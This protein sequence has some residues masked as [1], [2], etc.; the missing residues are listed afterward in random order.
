M[1][2]RNAE[3]PQELFYWTDSEFNIWKG[4]VHEHEGEVMAGSFHSEEPHST[5]FK[6]VL[7]NSK[8]TKV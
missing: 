3:V 6:N 5:L 1:V 2:L 7:I 4:P 8:V